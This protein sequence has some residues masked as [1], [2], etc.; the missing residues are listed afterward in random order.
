MT[1]EI[2][3]IPAMPN[4]AL[5]V[6]RFNPNAQD[7]SSA[8]LDSIIR[9]DK[10]M[11]SNI[12]R[13]A[14]SAYYGQSGR[15]KTLKDAITLLGLKATK[16]LVLLIA[17]SEM[18]GRLKNDAFRLY[19]HERSILSALVALDL[20]RP[21]GT[22]S[23][24][25]EAFLAG[26]LHNT[27]MSI[28]ALNAPGAYEL[29]LTMIQERGGDLIE[30]EE[31][32]IGTNHKVVGLQAFDQWQMPPEQRAV[33]EHYDCAPTV[34]GSMDPLIRICSLAVVVVKRLQK[35][36]AD[37][38][39]LEREKRIL[40]SFHRDVAATAAFDESYYTLIQDHPFYSQAMNI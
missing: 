7:A 27:G 5:E 10:G 13:I 38:I 11:A 26:L 12:M 2:N 1:I 9:P 25:D 24:R 36:A 4:L 15:V 17:G 8:R 6:L 33:L 30:Q 32:V 21:L 3:H 31:K 37:E 18:F 22:A 20:C 14:N 28:I 40:A 23:L 29:L 16:N 39:D 34:A 35:Q 19:I